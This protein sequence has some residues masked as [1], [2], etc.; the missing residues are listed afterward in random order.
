MK[1]KKMAFL[2][3][4]ILI[5][6]LAVSSVFA[7]NGLD[8]I[9]NESNKIE[10]TNKYSAVLYG[11]DWQR[12]YF[13]TLYDEKQEKDI[14]LEIPAIND[15]VIDEEQYKAALPKS[16][17]LKEFKVIENPEYTPI[18]IRWVDTIFDIG[19][20]TLSAL[21]FYQNPTLWN[22]FNVVL[23]GLSV[24]LPF[25]PSVTGVKRMIQASDDLADALRWGVARYDDLRDAKAGISRF[26][27]LEA[28]HIIEKRFI[29]A[30]EEVPTINSMLAINI[31]K[32]YHYS[33]T[34]KM[35]QM[36]PYGSNYA[37]LGRSY[38]KSRVRK[39]YRELYMQTGDELYEFLYRYVDES[40]LFHTNTHQ[41]IPIPDFFK[42]Y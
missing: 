21:E 6:N 13:I 31:P 27:H 28:H 22:G 33:I 26:S 7:S 38:I 34:S 41:Y 9:N 25:V 15:G 29:D 19:C 17:E 40:D 18:G 42:T 3:A 11:D 12:K 20:L 35:Q 16:I 5:F 24:A 32:P 1:S 8:Q 10:Y 37:H 36:V 23:D 14:V 2:L 39:G 30:F 4:F